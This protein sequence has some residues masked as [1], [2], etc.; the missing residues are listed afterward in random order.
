MTESENGFNY[1]RMFNIQISDG[2]K[3]A[4]DYG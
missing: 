2:L 4:T 1:V 3:T